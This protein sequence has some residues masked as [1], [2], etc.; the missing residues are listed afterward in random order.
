M[1]PTPP[2]AFTLA[3]DPDDEPYTDLAIA[4]T[5]HYLVSRDKDLLDLMNQE[6]PE[7]KELRR[8]SPNLRILAP[9]TFLLAITR[10]QPLP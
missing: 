9:S 6:T 10:T 8:R 3:R 1:H 5:T 4:T 7:G 2:H